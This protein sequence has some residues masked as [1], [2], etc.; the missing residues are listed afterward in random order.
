M[1]TQ[2]KLLGQVQSLV[3]TWP[4]FSTP[5]SKLMMKMIATKL[6]NISDCGHTLY[7]MFQVNLL[8]LEENV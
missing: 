2:T 5:D 3:T 1:F 6:E 7:G 8:I 4:F